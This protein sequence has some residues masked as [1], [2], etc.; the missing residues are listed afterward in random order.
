MARMLDVRQPR[1]IHNIF[2]HNVD[3]TL[4]F[5]FFGRSSR[6]SNLHSSCSARF[7][8]VS[9][10]TQLFLR[11]VSEL[12]IAIRSIQEIGTNDLCSSTNNW[13]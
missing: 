7:S 12:V 4:L 6:A 9:D 2:I 11:L 5:L 1:S 10:I 13:L 3:L 8:T